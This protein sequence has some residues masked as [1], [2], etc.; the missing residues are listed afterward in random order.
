MRMA[1]GAGVSAALFV[2]GA[3]PS[4]AQEDGLRRLAGA[5]VSP[6]TAYVALPSE[7]ICAAGSNLVIPS[8]DGKDVLILRTVLPPVATTDALLQNDYDRETSL[9]KSGAVTQSEVLLLSHGERR[10]QVVWRSSSSLQAGLAMTGI[11]RWLPGTRTALLTVTAQPGPVAPTYFDAE[12]D[13]AQI[14]A[15]RAQQ[16]TTLVRINGATGKIQTLR[17]GIGG[18]ARL[19]G[20]STD[21]VAALVGTEEPTVQRIGPD[22]TV[23]PV[24]RWQYPAVKERP[25]YW[26]GFLPDGKTLVGTLY[27]SGPDGKISKRTFLRLDTQT[28]IVTEADKES[29][30]RTYN[31]PQSNP[32]VPLAVHQGSETVTRDDLKTTI[33]PLWLEGRGGGVTGRILISSDS[34]GDEKPFVLQNGIVYQREGAVYL[35]PL[36]KVN[37]AQFLAQKREAQRKETIER[38]ENIG[39]AL[40]MYA[41]D[42][43]QSLPPQGSDLASVLTRYL[44]DANALN[45]PATEKPGFTVAYKIVA[46]GAIADRDKTPLGYLAGPGGRAILFADGSVEWEQADND[47]Q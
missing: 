20:S 6:K 31:P 35:V 4:R 5:I 14:K 8:P 41:G 26:R 3:E 10:A 2:L 7:L 22:G 19:V 32:D 30:V 17:T 33:R 1:I 38:A 37:T 15:E 36:L 18:Y 47:K 12:R 34:D 25:P 43:E 9:L 45:N 21:S 16:T 11:A 40:L 13:D 39:M 28:G 42:H 24:V 27:E 23:G 44:G 46:L 29:P